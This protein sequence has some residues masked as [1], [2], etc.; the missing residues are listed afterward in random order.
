MSMVKDVHPMVTHIDI[1]MQMVTAAIRTNQS[2]T[3]TNLPLMLER[4]RIEQVS[5]VY[6]FSFW[7]HSSQHEYTNGMF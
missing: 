5:L 6:L 3:L 4:A 2:G 1:T 7:A